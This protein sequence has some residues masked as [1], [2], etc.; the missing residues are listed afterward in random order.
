MRSILANMVD[1]P[2]EAK[3]MGSRAQFLAKTK[4]NYQLFS[5]ELIAKIERI[6]SSKYLLQNAT[7]LESV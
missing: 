5:D 4:Y 2:E 3:E 6:S 1:N 7:T